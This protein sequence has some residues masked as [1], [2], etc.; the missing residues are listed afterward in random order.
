MGTALLLSG[1]LTVDDEDGDQL[2]GGNTMS[3]YHW[4]AEDGCQ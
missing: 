2:L 3:H 1:D 4:E